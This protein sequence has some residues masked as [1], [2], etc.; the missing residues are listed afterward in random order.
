MDCILLDTNVFVSATRSRAGA[1]WQLLNLAPQQ[2]FRLALSVSLV[3]E[4]EDAATRAHPNKTLSDADIEQLV[5]DLC[6]IAHLQEVYYLW[7]P[8]LRDS[9]DDH[10]LE[11]A[12]AANCHCIVTYNLRDFAGVTRQ[13]GI[14]I[15]KPR[16][17][18]ERLGETGGL[19]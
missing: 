17:Y 13:F 12:V 10:V 19:L 7:R 18:L 2:K 5:S 4:Y 11:L 1:S 9:H 14:E 8:F 16:Q 15:L 3:T 6:S